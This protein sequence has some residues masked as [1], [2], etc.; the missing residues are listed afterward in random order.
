MD[1]ITPLDQQIIDMLSTDTSTTESQND[2]PAT[3]T[4]ND[5][6]ER[7]I[8]TRVFVRGPAQNAYVTVPEISPLLRDENELPALM[9]NDTLPITDPCPFS[10]S[11]YEKLPISLD[12]R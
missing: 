8:T 1:L 9:V 4:T 7:Q 3:D 11:P 5:T 2:T 10:A 6:D 12:N